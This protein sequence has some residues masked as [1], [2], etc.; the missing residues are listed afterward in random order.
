M[1]KSTLNGTRLKALKVSGFRARL[2]TKQGRKI[3]KNRRMKGRYKLA[4]SFKY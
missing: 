3:L 4:I 2:A 1:S